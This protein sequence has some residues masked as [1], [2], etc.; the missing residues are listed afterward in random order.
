MASYN[1]AWKSGITPHNRSRKTTNQ[2]AVELNATH[3]E[4]H[5]EIYF[6]IILEVDF[7]KVGH[8]GIILQLTMHLDMLVN[9]TGKMLKVMC[10]NFL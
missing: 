10:T 3:K 1:L 4:F 5:R 7:S 2:K 8:A 9:L 6:H